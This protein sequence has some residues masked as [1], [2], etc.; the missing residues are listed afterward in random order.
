MTFHVI[1]IACT[2]SCRKDSCV[3]LE[4]LF[5]LIL[6]ALASSLTPGPNNLMLLAS[7]VN[8]G[9]KKT[10]PHMFGVSLGFAFMAVL[11]GL[12]IMQVF[13]T[14]PVTYLILKV[15]SVAYLLF[16]ALKIARSSAPIGQQQIKGR[17]MTFLQAV[18]FQWVNPKAW[19]M[20]LM[21]ISVYAPTKSFDAILFVALVFSAV[22][23]PCIAC[24]AGL[25]T[26]IKRRL[27]APTSLKRFNYVMAGLL[28][29]SL[30]PILI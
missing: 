27:Q 30:Y 25:G 4:I 5:A 12:G 16:L 19:S 3:T 22:N 21:A 14:Y 29:T 11:V 23:F 18:M 2:L 7:G 10:L 20:A 8:F 28:V 24:W 9:F 17:P 6:Y 13:D 1:I 15:L 26:N